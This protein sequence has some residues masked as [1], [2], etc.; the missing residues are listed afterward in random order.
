[1]PVDFS[2]APSVGEQNWSFYL[3]TGARE[4]Q[5]GVSSPGTRAVRMQAFT[6]ADFGI[7]AWPSVIGDAVELRIEV[8][9]TRARGA[10][11]A[12][13]AGPEPPAATEVE[14]ALPPDANPADGT[15]PPATG[16]APVPEP[17]RDEPTPP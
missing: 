5:I 17:Q 16:P 4:Y 11:D 8:E 6:L 1:M 7:D 3:A 10:E 13:E 14:P 2:A 9:A 15:E 12:G